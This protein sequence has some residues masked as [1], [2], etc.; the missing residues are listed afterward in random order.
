[1]EAA[2]A[3]FVDLNRVTLRVGV[4]IARALVS[5]LRQLA[6]LSEMAGIFAA[7]RVREG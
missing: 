1:M 4:G 2:Q 5:L 3:F 7:C 6:S